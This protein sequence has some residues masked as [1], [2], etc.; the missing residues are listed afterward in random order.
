M[1]C[2]WHSRNKT[3]FYVSYTTNNTTA[4]CIFVCFG[5]ENVL[6]SVTMKHQYDNV[7]VVFSKH[8]CRAVS[9]Y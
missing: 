4:R 8:L 9:I 3:Q 7:P 5:P 2:L 6:C 1:Y